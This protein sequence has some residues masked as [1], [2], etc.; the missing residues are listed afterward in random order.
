MENGYKTTG[1]SA[2]LNYKRLCPLKSLEKKHDICVTTKTN[3]KVQR[4][5]CDDLFNSGINNI[6]LHCF[7]NA[8]NSGVNLAL[9]L[10]N[11]SCGSLAYIINSSTIQLIDE[12]NAIF[13]GDDLTWI[14]RRNSVLHIN[15]FRC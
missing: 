13:D 15:I 10:V 9:H 1:R 11:S 6:Y 12:N 3:L 7:G 4:K 8:I 5:K 2:K 14:Q